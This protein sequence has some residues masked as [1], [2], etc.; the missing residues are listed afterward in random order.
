LTWPRSN[1]RRES[2]FLNGWHISRS[3]ACKNREQ[4]SRDRCRKCRNCRSRN[5]CGISFPHTLVHLVSQRTM[6]TW[7]T[8]CNRWHTAETVSPSG[9]GW[10]LATVAIAA[11]VCPMEKENP[12]KNFPDRVLCRK[13]RSRNSCE[14]AVLNA[15]QGECY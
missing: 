13:C 3:S 4:Q 15:V 7:R 2:R 8:S 1:R 14:W 9:F 5:S 11:T 12:C 10:S 6:V